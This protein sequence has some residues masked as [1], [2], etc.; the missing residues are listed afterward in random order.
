MNI[1]SG[2]QA[3]DREAGTRRRTS[4]RAGRPG[5]RE[6][7]ESIA[8]LEARGR[9]LSGRRL[10]RQGTAQAPRRGARQAQDGFGPCDEKEGGQEVWR[11]LRQAVGMSC[12][13]IRPPT[14]LSQ[15]GYRRLVA[16]IR[17]ITRSRGGPYERHWGHATLQDQGHQVGPHCVT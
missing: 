6:H 10:H 11:L 9:R 7:A 1:Y 12:Q 5:S 15:C 17:E 3:G 13:A 4:H 2:V 16:T 14:S 8:A